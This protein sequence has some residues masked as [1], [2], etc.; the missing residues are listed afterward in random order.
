MEVCRE[1]EGDAKTNAANGKTENG[2]MEEGQEGKYETLLTTRGQPIDD[3][4]GRRIRRALN[5]L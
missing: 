3:G 4:S 5:Q 2:Q 1:N